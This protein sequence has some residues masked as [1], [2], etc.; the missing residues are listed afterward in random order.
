MLK[1]IKLAD[2][3]LE[4]FKSEREIAEKK[5]QEKKIDW[6]FTIGRIIENSNKK[7]MISEIE[8]DNK[9]MLKEK[10]MKEEQIEEKIIECKEKI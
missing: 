3:L 5:L 2:D 1:N 4:Q 9:N 10:K 8:V 6:N 7:K